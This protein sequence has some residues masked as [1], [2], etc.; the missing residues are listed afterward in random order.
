M[1]R[2][3]GK[4]AVITG[5]GSGIGRAAARLFVAEGAKV[6]VAEIDAVL[7]EAGYAQY[8][9]GHRRGHGFGLGSPL[10]GDISRDNEMMLEPGMSFVVHPNQYLP[11][12]GYVLC[13]EPVIVTEAG[14]EPIVHRPAS[15]DVVPV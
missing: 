7:G 11:E 9:T 10:P 14:L 15:L 1:N 8:I 3:A 6:V 2:L 5:A 12:T 4:V 13:G